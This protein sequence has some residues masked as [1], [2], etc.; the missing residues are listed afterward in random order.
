MVIDNGKVE[1]R[2]DP[3]MYD[4]NPRMRDEL[5][6]AL[7]DRF[8][9]AQLLTHSTY[10]LSD[11]SMYRLHADGRRDVTVFPKGLAIK[12][13]F[14]SVDI[15]ITDKDGSVVADTRK[16]RI[17]KKRELAELAAKHRSKDR[18]LESMLASYG[19]SI[20]DPNN[21]LVHLYEIRDALSSRFGGERPAKTALQISDAAWSEFGKL[22]N[23]DP[24]RQGRHRGKKAGKL[25]D[26]TEAELKTA[27][28]FAR[29]IIEAYF[30]HLE[31]GG[32]V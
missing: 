14:G 18:T 26:A 9:G 1:A 10:E 22:A 15:V 27:R 19:A 28:I 6:D 20:R 17:D 23:E 5:H 31:G 2:M 12:T 8:L 30:Q 13:S 16:D 21:E 3:A 25:R 7:N 4:K 29:S 11:A 24:I 32:L